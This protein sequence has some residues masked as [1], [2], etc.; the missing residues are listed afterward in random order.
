LWPLQPFLGTAFAFFRGGNHSGAS[1]KEIIMRTTGL[2]ELTASDVMTREVIRLREDI[3]L[4]EA[5]GLLSKNQIGGAP[6]VDGQGKCVGV[7]SAVDFIHLAIHARGVSRTASAPLPL[8]CPYQL[9]HRALNGHETKLCIL[10]MG[11]CPVQREQ[12]GADGGKLITCSQPHCVLADWQVV[13]MEKTPADEVRHSMTADPVMVGPDTPLRIVARL[14]IDAH[15]HR[16]IV[17]D[18]AQRPIGIVSGT[19]ILAALAYSGGEQ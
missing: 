12:A 3:P 15:V 17:V 1:F 18:E 13:D 5:A 9:K 11:A 4:W 7:L 16:V 10:P 6:V 19:D 2:L 8:S 14:M